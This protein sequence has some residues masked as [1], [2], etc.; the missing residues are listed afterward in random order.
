[1]SSQNTF[2]YSVDGQM[3]TTNDA[4]ISG[5]QIRSQVGLRPA[6]DHILIEIGS[7]TTR[8]IGLEENI[9]LTQTQPLGFRSFAGD[10][11]YTFTVNERGYE[12][13]ADEISTIDLRTYGD[14]PDDHELILDSQRDRP[15]DDDDFV[16]LRP[17]G[18]ERI[19]SRPVAKICIIVNT[20]EEYV[21]P[22]RLSFAELAKLAFPDTQVTPYT[23][24]TVS[25]RKGPRNS[26]EGSLI[27]G[28]SIKLK[29]G[30][31]FDV[32]ETDKS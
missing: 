23:E 16:R 15:I 25:Y 32:S 13:G 7:H 5:R 3:F 30:M 24:Y 1:M 14:I 20:I 6:S 17:K 26:P 18:V 21:S 27:D 8:S 9:D 31:I 29:K 19:I 22:G 12:W 2:K 28:E 4:I 10:R 11:I